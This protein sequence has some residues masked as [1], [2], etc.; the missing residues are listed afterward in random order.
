MDAQHDPNNPAVSLFS[1][2]FSNSTFAIPP[3]TA[4][5]NL[6]PISSNPTPLLSS[7]IPLN[8]F[9]LVSP[10]P[11]TPARPPFNPDDFL[12]SPSPQQSTNPG[13]LV[14]Q[15][16]TPELS[17]RLFSHNDTPGDDPIAALSNTPGVPSPK[18]PAFLH[19][20]DDDNLPSPMISLSFSSPKHY[21]PVAMPPTVSPPD[22]DLSHALT[23]GGALG[24]STIADDTV[25]IHNNT[26][27][28]NSSTLLH[29]SNEMLTPDSHNVAQNLSLLPA[30]AS[31]E[32]GK[33]HGK[34]R[35]K[36]KMST[37][38]SKFPQPGTMLGTL[39]LPSSQPPS[40]N[41]A[42]PTTPFTPALPSKC[43]CS[44]KASRCLKLYC[45]CF[46]N[47][48]F[49]SPDCSCRNCLNTHDTENSV[50]DA[51]EAVLLRDP[52]AFDPKLKQ[53]SPTSVGPA[54]R[55]D[56][57][58]KGCNCRK[59][60][61]KRYCVCRE[62]QVECGPRCTCSGP[63]GCMN[64]KT[65][66]PED[67]GKE[68]IPNVSTLVASSN[69]KPSIETVE[70][71]NLTLKDLKAS[72]S[73]E[74]LRGKELDAEGS[75]MSGASAGATLNAYEENGCT[76][77]SKSG[78]M[79]DCVVEELSTDKYVHENEEPNSAS[80]GNV[81]KPNIGKG[82]ILDEKHELPCL[83]SD[84]ML[85]K[86][87]ENSPNGGGHAN[88]GRDLNVVQVDGKIKH[89]TGSDEIGKASLGPG[90]VRGQEPDEVE[91]C[92]LPRILRVK[93]GSGRR[94]NKYSL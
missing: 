52:R 64:R 25:N 62:L 88:V 22:C 45:L 53:P 9:A 30:D 3:T 87:D 43:K 1:D 5:L 4:Q 71:E 23:S 11:S 90:V 24:G 48:G 78:N 56:I 18:E 44:C 37:P 27:L 75:S 73:Q 8:P 55:T 29:L 94:Q 72:S 61:T 83:P 91:V 6:P 49:C 65:S 84:S 32:N 10:S 85:E 69:H 15:R 42:L 33:R 59:G 86:N 82:R 68:S 7:T 28:L 39:I 20:P 34:T 19:A 54:R 70:D 66:N 41:V 47:S 77:P 16:A 21:L 58:F 81:L 12:I 36:L 76:E 2:T 14:I 50:R 17:R 38:S 79:M 92:R 57:H 67:S 35:K 63:D 74:L 80:E 60:C 31:T 13:R 93:M 26:S 89:R 40:T 46:A 51:R